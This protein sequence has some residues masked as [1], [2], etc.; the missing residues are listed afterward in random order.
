MFVKQSLSSL[1]LGEIGRLFGE[2]FGLC[3]D[4]RVSSVAIYRVFTPAAVIYSIF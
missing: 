2:M 4:I 3:V 1:G